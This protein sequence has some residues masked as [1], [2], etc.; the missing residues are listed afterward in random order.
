[1]NTRHPVRVAVCWAKATVDSR[2]KVS[3]NFT[4]TLV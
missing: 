3:T 2:A 1:L 4:T